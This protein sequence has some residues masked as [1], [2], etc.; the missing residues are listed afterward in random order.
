MQRSSCFFQ[1]REIVLLDKFERWRKVVKI[2]KL[3]KAARLR[4]EWIIF[5]YNKA[6][7]NAR[8]TCRYFGI[9][10]K[11]FYKWLNLFNEENLKSLEDRSKAPKTQR[12]PEYTPQEIQRVIGLRLKYP[13]LGRDKLQTIYQEEYN[14]TIRYWSLRRIICDFKLYAQRA[15]RSKR[16]KA[17]PGVIKKK[18][19][20]ELKKEPLAGFLLELDGLVIYFSNVNMKTKVLPMWSPMT[21]I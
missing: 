14:E 16:Q 4:L 17:Q 12:K 19:I 6:K 15:V 20:T 7:R 1:P 8:L 18:R 2:L 9:S 10:P 21:K 3:S 5:Y 13:T 11:T